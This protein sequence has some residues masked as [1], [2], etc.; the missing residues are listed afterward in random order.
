MFPFA[1]RGWRGDPFFV[2]P[3]H[4]GLTPNFFNYPITCFVRAFALSSAPQAQIRC[5]GAKVAACM[6]KWSVCP[7]ARSPLENIC[8]GL[9]ARNPWR[10]STWSPP[11]PS[12]FAK[13][14]HRR[15]VGSS[16]YASAAVEGFSMMKRATGAQ[17]TSGAGARERDGYA[18]YRQP[19]PLVGAEKV[20]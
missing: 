19:A 3:K 4:S 7:I 5:L 9:V 14:M 1:Y 13:A 18:D 2:C 10:F 17:D 6:M 12:R 20:N 8:S 15:I 16:L 11:H